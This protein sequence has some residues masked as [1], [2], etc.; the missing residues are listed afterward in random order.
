MRRAIELD[1]AFSQEIS[2]RELIDIARE[3]GL[4]SKAIAQALREARAPGPVRFDPLS[5]YEAA[6][7]LDAI[8]RAPGWVRRVIRRGVL[9]GLS[10]GAPV[11]LLLALTTPSAEL[12]PGGQVSVILSF[13]AL[14]LLWTMPFSFGA[15]WLSLRSLNRHKSDGRSLLE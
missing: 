3:L 2:E 14:T 8:E 15:R 4:S 9:L 11:G 13:T 10:I 12:P 7:K 6:Q 5:L 1:S